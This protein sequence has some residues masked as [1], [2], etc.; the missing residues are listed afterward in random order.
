MEEE[1]NS[2][3]TEGLNKST[4]EHRARQSMKSWWDKLTRNPKKTVRKIIMPF[5][6]KAAIFMLFVAGIALLGL[7]IV[8]AVEGLLTRGV[9]SDISESRG[10]MHSSIGRGM[11]SLGLEEGDF[12]I[13]IVR[14]TDTGM[15]TFEHN[16]EPEE[17]AEFAEIL[18]EN[19]INFEEMTRQELRSITPFEIVFLAMLHEHGLDLS[20]YCIEGLRTLILF[21]KAALSTQHLDIRTTEQVNQGSIEEPPEE[22]FFGTIQVTKTTRGN[23]DNTTRLEY[24]PLEEFQEQIEENDQNVLNFFSIDEY[25]NLVIAGWSSFESEYE[26]DDGEAPYRYRPEGDPPGEPRT[27]TME[28]VRVPYQSLVNR[29]TMPFDFLVAILTVSNNI[30]FGRDVAMLA[31]NSRIV[32]NVR[33]VLTETQTVETQDFAILSN[34]HR[35]RED[36]SGP[37]PIDTVRRS[38]W[39]QTDEFTIV[40][41]S[42]RRTNNYSF[43]LTEIYTWFKHAHIVYGPMVRGDEYVTNNNENP[44]IV[45]TPASEASRSQDQVESPIVAVYT[46][47][48]SE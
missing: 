46:R 10:S 11:N 16:F 47:T 34:I 4:R 21:E 28:E 1:K 31:F 18:G 25:E 29:H 42:I 8:A 2:N 5:I 38:G 19:G 12:R 39:H 24:M 26:F 33:E 17:I 43:A 48:N 3:P 32:V 41:R 13:A 27:Y 14:N 44:F 9:A 37:G 36:T 40:N 20:E 22:G 23:T 35:E 15:Y 6:I 45:Y 7:V 30:P